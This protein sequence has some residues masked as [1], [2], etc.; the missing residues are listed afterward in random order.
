MDPISAIGFAASILT[1]IEFASKIVAG[2]HEVYTSASGT[3]EENAHIDTVI[4]DLRETADSLDSDLIGKTKHEKALK[5]LAS[6]CEIL[7]TELLTLLEQLR[8][9]GKNSTWKSLK[10]TLKSMRKEKV[11]G[12]MEKRLGEYRSQMLLRLSLMLKYYR[13]SRY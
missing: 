12:G 4:T 5:E 2:A 11:V 13:I 7:S 9:S 10:I 1:F 6:K 3:T 8:L